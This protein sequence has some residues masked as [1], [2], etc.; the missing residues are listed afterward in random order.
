MKIDEAQFRDLRCKLLPSIPGLA[1]RIQ[2]IY[3]AMRW[4]WA[5]GMPSVEDIE[6]E[7]HHLIFSLRNVPTAVEFQGLYARWLTGTDGNVEGGE[8]GFS[9]CDCALFKEEAI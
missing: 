7:F 9:I 8:I 2:P 3:K 4:E 1:E 5:D 6:I